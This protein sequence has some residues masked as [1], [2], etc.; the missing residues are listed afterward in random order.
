MIVTWSDHLGCASVGRSF[1]VGVW[2]GF[3]VSI[4][5]LCG[6]VSCK[7][8]VFWHLTSLFFYPEP[9]FGIRV[10]S[11]PASAFVPA[12]VS[13]C[14]SVWAGFEVSIVL[15]CGAVSCKPMVFWHLTSLFFYPEPNFG[16][17]VLSLPASA[18]V[19]ACV[20]VCVSVW[21]GFEVSI[22]LLC[23]AVSCKPMVFWHLTSLFFIPSPILALGCYRCLPLH[24][25][26]RVCPCVFPCVNL[27]IVRALTHHPSKLGSPNLDQWCKAAFLRFFLVWRLIDLDLQGQI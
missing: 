1:C 22:V 24:L 11:L 6:A 18:F 7:P 2:A 15:L 17:R 23:G 20:S 16:I 26:P 4:V 21:A 25:C 19:P 14:V 13:V 12:C 3:E 27:E 10:L 5:L 8:M 9:N